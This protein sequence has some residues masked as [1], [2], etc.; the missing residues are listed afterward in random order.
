MELLWLLNCG[1]WTKRSGMRE[2]GVYKT[3]AEVGFQVNLF[4]LQPPRQMSQCLD[5]IGDAHLGIQETR[6]SKLFPEFSPAPSPVP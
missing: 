2:V 5:E 6:C 3:V 1:G 4:M